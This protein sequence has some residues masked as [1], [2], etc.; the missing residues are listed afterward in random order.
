MTHRTPLKTQV[1]RLLGCDYP[2]VSAGMGGVAR[3]ELVAAVV[4]AGGYGLLGMVRE[5]PDLIRR[6]IAAVR[7]RTDRHFGVNLI[8]FGTDPALL[9]EEL[10]ACF[11]S[12][13]HSL[14]FFWD[15]RPDLIQRARAAG[16]KVLY[17][18]GRLTDAVAAATAGADVII[19]QG[20]EA[21]GHVHGEVSSLVL[22]PQIVRAVDV[23]VLAS[24][25]FATG[26]GLVAAFALGAQGIHCGTA[27]LA[28]QESF[29]HEFHKRRVVEA[30]S[31]QT[32]HSDVFAI[33]WPPRSPVRTLTN[34]VTDA[35][36]DDLRGHGPDDFPR[37]VIGQ[38]DQRPIYKF[39]TD[40]PLQNMTGD[41]EAMAPFAGQVCGLIEE[42]CP[43]GE[44]LRRIVWEAETIFAQ[45]APS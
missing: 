43:A 40:S 37:E 30:T 34:S 24:G 16:C 36:R 28:T 6:E 45:F 3:S 26:G 20:V 23:P 12:K 35:Y 21:G 33:N 8:P 15:V 31:E 1:C 10:A 19:C 11:E 41:F 42:I 32:V 25:G 22:L 17:Q 29:A 38:E 39:S 27:F 4:A 9:D 18:V 5:S 7:A 44:R 14:C 13:A 2:I